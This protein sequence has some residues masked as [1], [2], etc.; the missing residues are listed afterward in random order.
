ME[1]IEQAD[2]SA[3]NTLSLPSI[4]NLLVN[5]YTVDELVAVCKKNSRNIEDFLILGGGSN[6]ILPARVNRVVYRYLGAS[7]QYQQIGSG[8]VL[9]KAD[10]GVLWDDLVADLV[11]QNL[12]G[13]EN[14]SLIPGTVGAAPVQNIGAFGVELADVLDSVEVLNFNTLTV[15]VL[16]KEQCQFAYRDSVFKQNPGCYFIT[17]V[18]LKLSQTP[19]FTLNYGDLKALNNKKDL[20]VQEVRDKVI[21]LRSAKLPDPK[22]LPN[23]GSFFK[24]PLVSAD[25]AQQLKLKYPELVAY[26]QRDGQVKLAAGWLIEH[27]NWKGKRLGSVGMHA[28]Q[29]LVLVNYKSASQSEVL[30][31]AAQVQSSVSAKYDVSLEI[32]PITIAY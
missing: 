19:G 32:E 27:V 30:A 26:P 16:S 12:H 14:L 23:A 18:R 5:I 29:A 7:V 13:I 4:A 15:E 6:L 3:L 31:L 10:A 1:S 20:V 11:S 28:K 25:K 8:D 24:N 21:A 17:N 22:V 2:L 9:V